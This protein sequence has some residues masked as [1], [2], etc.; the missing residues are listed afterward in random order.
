M[1]SGELA[2]QMRALLAEQKSSWD[3]LAKGYA[4]LGAVKTRTLRIDGIV[5]ELQFN[6]QRIVSSGAKVDEKS[7]REQA[8]QL[9]TKLD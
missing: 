5:I 9:L 1:E 6:P 4:S 3:M 7:I 2:D 8:F